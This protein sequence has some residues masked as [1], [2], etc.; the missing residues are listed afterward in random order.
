M[1]GVVV[2]QFLLTK[3]TSGAENFTER[4]LKPICIG[5]KYGYLMYKTV[6][7]MKIHFSKPQVLKNRRFIH[8]QMSPGTV[9]LFKPSFKHKDEA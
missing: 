8:R 1:A 7:I 4:S 6:G 3:S 5:E 9:L 2:Y